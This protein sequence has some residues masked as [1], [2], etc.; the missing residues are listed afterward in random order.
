MKKRLSMAKF[1]LVVRGG[2]LV[3]GTGIPRYTADV[4]LRDGRIAEIVSGDVLGG[5]ISGLVCSED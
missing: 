3:D 2:H 4:G 1:E 5:S